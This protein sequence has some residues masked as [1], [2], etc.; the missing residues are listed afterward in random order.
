MR[1][2]RSSSIKSRGAAFL[3][4]LVCLF[5]VPAQAQP[6]LGSGDAND[7]YQIFTPAQM[8]AIGADLAGCEPNI[9]QEWVARY[10]GLA[11]LADWA[12]AIAVDKLGCIYIA[13]VSYNGVADSGYISTK[14]N[15]NGVQLWSVEYSGPAGK[16]DEAR[17]LV[18]DDSGNVYVTGIV[19]GDT[20]SACVTIK[21]NSNGDEVWVAN[22]N[23]GPGGGN[24]P[25]DIAVDKQGYVYITGKSNE[26][27]SRPEY[28]T[29]KYDPNGNEI[30]SNNYNPSGWTAYSIAQA[31]VVDGLGN[32]YVTGCSQE[33]D[34]FREDYATIKYDV[35]GIQ[36][37][38]ARYDKSE[39]S[40]EA[41]D[42]ALDD[43]G[44]VYVTGA[45]FDGSVSYSQD[46]TTIKY[47]PNGNEVWVARY[48]EGKAGEWEYGSFIS[49]DKVGSVCVSGFAT[50]M[51]GTTADY[52]T[53]KYDTSGNEIWDIRYNGPANGNDKIS[54]MVLDESGNVY[55]TG[56]SY[57]GSNNDY[58]T[59][60]YDPNG[61][62]VWV[63][64]YDG[65]P[66]GDDK[67][68]GVSIDSLANVYITGGS[69]GNG[70]DLDCATIRYTQACI[71]TP[72]ITGDI[73]NNCKVDFADLKILC[74]QWLLEE[75]SA[76]VAPDGGDWFVN[77]FDWAV[78]ANQWQI[79]VGFE[80]LA[81]FAEQWLKTGANYY[82]ADIAPTSDG[83]GIVNVLDFAALADNWLAGK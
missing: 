56:C 50:G 24:T 66:N 25:T 8:N 71:C 19:F 12:N 57:N 15:P 61:N 21:Y 16:R 43:S 17:A 77:F 74:E 13:G 34:T 41:S 26:S 72:E 65:P 52:L 47:D 11:D 42:I 59:V 1:R 78:F 30:W 4:L 18:V 80:A 58:A 20:N 79:T 10:N 37:W 22:Y 75:L 45:S 76:D 73:S 32:V 36:L 63:V 14:Y 2:L 9:T 28:L 70:T 39:D 83:D 23:S 27:G 3:A 46:C 35:N 69:E 44:N 48:N 62:E 55:V 29:V 81:D 6:W 49:L 54:G 60:K 38:V 53:V 7:P 51:P 67:A 31:L 40:D 33:N 5:S 68:M 64:R 82:I